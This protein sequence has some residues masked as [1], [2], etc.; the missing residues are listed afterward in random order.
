MKPQRF[1][2]EWW[3][4]YAASWAQFRRTSTAVRVQ[5]PDKTYTNEPVP[6]KDIARLC[7]READEGLAAFAEI[8]PP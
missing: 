2:P 3:A 4:L 7:M 8:A 5:Q 1:G 6:A